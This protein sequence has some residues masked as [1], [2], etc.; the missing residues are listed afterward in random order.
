[1]KRVLA[2]H[3]H[4]NV[5]Q[6]NMMSN[7]ICSWNDRIELQKRDLLVTDH[8]KETSKLNLQSRVLYKW[9][10]KTQENRI[11]H[12]MGK[13]YRMKVMKGVLYNWREIK[14]RKNAKRLRTHRIREELNARPELGRPLKVLRNMLMFK[15]FN[16][17]FE[18]SHQVK[19]EDDLTEKAMLAF[20]LTRIKK[21]FLCLKLNAQL[22][23]Q[24]SQAA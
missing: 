8:I 10:S 2:K 16:K 6:R 13:F 14:D 21:T 23:Y 7:V 18:G 24:V 19:Q 20:Y 11:F 4:K 5:I 17:L 9:L 12:Q 15:A 1:M 22:K 3:F